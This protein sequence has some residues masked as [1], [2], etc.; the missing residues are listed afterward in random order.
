MKTDL[1]LIDEGV[2][3]FLFR[4]KKKY[5]LGEG[6]FGTINSLKV[7]KGDLY[8]FAHGL[9]NF[10]CTCGRNFDGSF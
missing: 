9:C 6:H 5:S 7:T 2:S 8:L 10:Y 3:C 4:T 1:T